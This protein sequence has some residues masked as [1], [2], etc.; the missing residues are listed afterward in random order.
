MPDEANCCLE[1]AGAACACGCV[2]NEEAAEAAAV[3]AVA[4]ALA[5]ASAGWWPV[6]GGVCE[7]PVAPEPMCRLLML[8]APVAVA[9]DTGDGGDATELLLLGNMFLLTLLFTGEI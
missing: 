4:A 1:K 8:T 2:W 3:A 7:N 9:A 6:S 5:V